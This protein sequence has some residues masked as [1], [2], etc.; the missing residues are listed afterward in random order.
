MRSLQRSLRNPSDGRPQARL[1]HTL[2]CRPDL[3]RAV[4]ASVFRALREVRTPDIGG[5]AT[6][7]EFTAAVHRQ[8]SWRRWQDLPE[9]E[10]AP[11]TEW[12]V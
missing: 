2:G 5:N 8:L 9:D 6:T 10:T 12:G 7:A 4:E 3:G 1:E 11:A